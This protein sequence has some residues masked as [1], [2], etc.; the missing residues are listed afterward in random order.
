MLLISYWPKNIWRIRF[1]ARIYQFTLLFNIFSNTAIINLQFEK[2]T[3][4]TYMILAL[5][6]FTSGLEA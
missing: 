5:G 2:S 3:L 1:C 4:I 6:Y